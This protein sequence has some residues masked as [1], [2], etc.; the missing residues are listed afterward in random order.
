MNDVEH[1]KSLLEMARGDLN[2]LRGMTAANTTS[3]EE[4]F[5]DEIFGFHAQQAAEKCLKAWLAARGRLYP[6]THD[7][8]ALIEVLND[9]GENTTSLDALV[10]LN[11]FAVQYRYESLDSD[12]DELDRTALISEVKSLFDHV[13]GV[14]SEAERNSPPTTATSP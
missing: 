2:S 14:I 13:A 4:F 9:A 1:A 8:M 3:T 11:P 6:R 10:D 12:D 7:L 5:S